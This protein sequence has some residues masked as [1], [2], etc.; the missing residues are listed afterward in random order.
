LNGS[1]NPNG[2][3][4]SIYLRYGLTANYGSFTFTNSA[5]SGNSAVTAPNAVLGLLPVTTYHFQ[6]MAFNSVGTNSGGDLTLHL[7]HTNEKVRAARRV[8]LCAC[9]T[10]RRAILAGPAPGGARNLYLTRT[11]RLSQIISTSVL[12]TAT[13]RSL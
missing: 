12:G 1:V 9:V 4:T 2:A 11:L 10:R 7:I 3:A 6:A 13:G 5:G 8:M